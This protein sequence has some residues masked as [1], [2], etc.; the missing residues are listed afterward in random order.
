MFANLPIDAIRDGNLS[1]EDSCV[2]K[3]IRDLLWEEWYEDAE[4]YLYIVAKD[5]DEWVYGPDNEMADRIASELG[6]RCGVAS[7]KL[8]EVIEE[9]TYI[10]YILRRFSEEDGFYH[11]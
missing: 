7:W 6:S 8:A 4:G 5:A 11:S 10:D 1:W 3:H 2:Q 9:L